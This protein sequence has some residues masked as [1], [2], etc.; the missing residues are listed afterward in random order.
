MHLEEHNLCLTQCFG[1]K[2]LSGTLLGPV[3]KTSGYGARQEML[4][5]AGAAALWVHEAHGA[6]KQVT[7]G[8]RTCSHDSCQRVITE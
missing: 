4:R 8:A 3:V 5:V 1:I 2:T 7:K 6:A